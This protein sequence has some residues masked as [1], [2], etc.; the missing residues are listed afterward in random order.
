MTKEVIDLLNACLP[1]ADDV[2]VFYASAVQQAEEDLK[3]LAES[4]PIECMFNCDACPDFN[5]ICNLAN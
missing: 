4:D 2:E 3:K 5:C 1:E